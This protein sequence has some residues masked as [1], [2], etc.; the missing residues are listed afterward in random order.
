MDNVIAQFAADDTIAYYTSDGAPGNR[1][2]KPMPEF[3]SGAGFVVEPGET[4]I[5]PVKPFKASHTVIVNHEHS[6]VNGLTVV[7]P[8]MSDDEVTTVAMKNTSRTRCAVLTGTEIAVA[9]HLPKQQTT[10]RGSKE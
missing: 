10:T 3:E 6:I 7:Y 4:V 2:A 5:I 1:Q 8:Q 9:Y